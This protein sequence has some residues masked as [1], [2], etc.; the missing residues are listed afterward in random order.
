MW[1]LSVKEIAHQL[2]CGRRERKTKPIL[3]SPASYTAFACLPPVVIIQALF[4][5]FLL[6]SSVSLPSSGA[7][8][9]FRNQLCGP[10][11]RADLIWSHLPA[12]IF[13]LY[14]ESCV[15][16]EADQNGMSMKLSQV[17]SLCLQSLSQHL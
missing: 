7:G 12:M 8:S 4:W 14:M 1:L 9:S 2:C 11:R 17:A 3:I 15:T 6:P 5:V 13:L 16:T 10:D